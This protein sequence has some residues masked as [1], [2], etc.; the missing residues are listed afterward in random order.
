[1]V[2]LVVAVIMFAGALLRRMFAGGAATITP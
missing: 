1:M 2:I